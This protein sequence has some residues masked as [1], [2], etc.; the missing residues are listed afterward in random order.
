V[1]ILIGLIVVGLVALVGG[2]E[3]IVR[4]GS[5]LAR[6]LRISSMVIGLT[7]VSIGTSLPELAVGIEGARRGAASL[8]VGNIVGSNI[9]NI[10]LVLG[11][12]ALLKP[13]VVD[14]PLV[15]FDLPVMVGVSVAVLVLGLLG[16]LAV[17][18]G[19]VLFFLGIAYLVVLLVTARRRA[20][21]EDIAAVTGSIPVVSPDGTLT[22]GEMPGDHGEFKPGVLY[23]LADVALVIAGLAV[24]V[25]GADWL[26][27]GATGI[28]EAM[29]VSE[30]IIG[31]TV[32]AFGTSVPE[33][34]TTVMASIRGDEGIA[35]G[36]V[37]GSCT[38]NLTL[39]LGGSLLFSGHGGAALDPSLIFVNLPIMVVVSLLTL[40]TCL[41]GRRMTRAN[42]ALFM[43]LYSGYLAYLIT[44]AAV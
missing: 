36:N 11:L 6:R 42:G 9:V 37:V 32:V 30:T 16:W 12:A 26:I 24:I 38:M 3:L 8:V 17:G 41:M 18:T 31:L 39:I 2:A 5:R 19:A 25:F 33:L 21:S 7:I 22:E 13:I 43:L 27:Q 34:A 4:F 10:L 20:A 44:T 40:V 35:V 28:A 29:G 1:G 23:L 14:T 15:R